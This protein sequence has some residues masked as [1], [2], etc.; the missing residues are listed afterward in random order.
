VFVINNVDNKDYDSC[1]HFE[2]ALHSD[3]SYLYQFLVPFSG[4]SKTVT[5]CPYVFHCESRNG[6]MHQ[7]NL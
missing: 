1:V 2:L 7:F 3:C 5:D 4:S 6:A